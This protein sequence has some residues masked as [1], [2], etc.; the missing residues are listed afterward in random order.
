M[1]HKKDW[2]SSRSQCE[3]CHHILAA[4]DLI[5]I[6]SWLWLRGRCRYCRETLGW[7]HPVQE[8]TLALAFIV[9]YVYW[10]YVFN[11][12]GLTLFVFWLVFLT[13]F[14]ALVVYDLKWM[15]LPNKIVYPLIALATVQTLAVVFAF[16]GGLNSLREAALGFLI[17]GGLFYALFQL[18][19]GKWIGGGDVKLGMLLG[20]VVG[21]PSKSLLLL[22]L[23]SLSGSAVAVPLLLSGRATKTT[24]VP[25]GPFLIIAGVVVQLFGAA[26]IDW[27]NRIL[28]VGG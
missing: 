17:S 10:P 11:A 23:A 22:F 6:F 14:L 24:R 5:P 25:F 3:H 7:Q 13:G 19:G 27:Y 9:S 20:I 21:G 28:V 26:L 18:S 12:K 4:Y 16:D 2:V 15:L 1:K 8:A